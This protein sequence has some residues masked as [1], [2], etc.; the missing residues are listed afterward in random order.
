MLRFTLLGLSLG[1]LRFVACAGDE[2]PPLKKKASPARIV[3]VTSKD[4]GRRYTL[5]VLD[6]ETS[7]W[8]PII[9]SGPAARLS[10]DGAVVA[11][12]RSGFV[13]T[14]P[15]KPRPTPT[16]IGQLGNLELPDVF[17]PQI[18]W[19]PDGKSIIATGTV[20]IGPDLKYETFRYDSKMGLGKQL[21][22]PASDFILDVSPDGHWLLTSGR[23]AQGSWQMFRM[24]LDGTGEVKLSHGGDGGGRFSPDG[25]RILFSHTDPDVE[26]Q[27]IFVMDTDGRDRRR[28]HT[29]AGQACWSPDGERFALATD[30][31]P[32]GPAPAPPK[33]IAAP[34]ERVQAAEPRPKGEPKPPQ[35]RIEIMDLQ[36]KRISV[37]PTPTGD[38]VVQ[39]DWR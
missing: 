22:V 25:T 9:R 36:G 39:L 37:H 38:P 19:C 34:T 31:R 33:R 28:V 7:E 24:R 4:L 15:L 6:P 10:P 16:V 18:A 32:P 13:F 27:G 17:S 23:R 3:A 8:Q 11:F 5:A 35:G 20:Q 14:A 30:D 2:P 21:L 1:I 12:G 29:F 26:K